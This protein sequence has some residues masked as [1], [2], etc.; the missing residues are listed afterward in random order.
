MRCTVDVAGRVARLYVSRVS[1]FQN[2]VPRLKLF[3][4]F[5]ENTDV[6]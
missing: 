4:P 6:S 5:A 1:V 3:V 2:Q